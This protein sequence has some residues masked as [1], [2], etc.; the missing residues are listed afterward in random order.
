[1]SISPEQKHDELTKD[2]QDGK[3]SQ[4]A[5]M[6]SSSQFLGTK[7]LKVGG[8]INFIERNILNCSSKKAA[9]IKRS[10]MAA[11]G[12]TVGGVVTEKKDN[13]LLSKSGAIQVQAMQHIGEEEEGGHE[14]KDEVENDAEHGR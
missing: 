2:P 5:A 11:K 9:E 1:M 7:R 3:P 10:E 14:C 13:L 12:T 8:K 4:Q 6:M